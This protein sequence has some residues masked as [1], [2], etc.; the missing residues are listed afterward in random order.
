VFNRVYTLVSKVAD[1]ASAAV[2]RG[3]QMMAALA[4][5]LK[6]PKADS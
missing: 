3:T 6:R 2:D 1:E 4:V 5:Y